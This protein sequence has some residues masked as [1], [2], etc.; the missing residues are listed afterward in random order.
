MDNLFQNELRTSLNLARKN[1]RVSSVSIAGEDFDLKDKRGNSIVLPKN[2]GDASFHNSLRKELYILDFEDLRNQFNPCAILD[3]G[4]ITK[5]CDYFIAEKEG[6]SI[7]IFNEITT[8]KDIYGLTTSI[9]D[10]KGNVQYQGGKIEKG[11]EQLLQSL[12]CV[13]KCTDLWTEI[14]SF[15]K[16]ICLF[17]YKLSDTSISEQNLFNLAL[18]FE[19]DE[20]GTVY[21]NKE[22]EKLGFE[23]RRIDY[24]P[25][26]IS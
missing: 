9:K 25:F 12:Q 17:S 26:K 16:R 8:S 11:Q 4:K 10:K 22:I 3:K 7:C 23:Y 19:N 1:I 15:S 13:E 20:N 18:S 6:K 24:T 21:P 5:R 2:T 14:R